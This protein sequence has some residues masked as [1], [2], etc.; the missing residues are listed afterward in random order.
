M[1]NEKWKINGL[2]DSNYIMGVGIAHPKFS[3]LNS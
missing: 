1:E 3:T 2:A